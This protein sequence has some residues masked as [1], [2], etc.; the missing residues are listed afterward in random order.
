MQLASPCSDGEG[1]GG[2]VRRR[3]S[4]DRPGAARVR[5]RR[6]QEI[7]PF[8]VGIRVDLHRRVRQGVAR[9]NE[10]RA[11]HD[12]CDDGR[13]DTAVRAIH[14]RDG[15]SWMSADAPR[16]DRVPESAGAVERD[17]CVS[18]VENDVVLQAV[19][20]VV[21]TEDDA[22]CVPRDVV[23]VDSDARAVE[24]R[25]PVAAIAS[26]GRAVRRIADA[27]TGDGRA[28]DPVHV[29][30][31]H[32]VARERVV[33]DVHRCVLGELAEIDVY[34]AA[35]VGTRRDTIGR[36]PARV[37]A[38]DVPARGMLD[39]DAVDVR[40][41]DVP[42]DRVGEHRLAARG[43]QRD[44]RLAV[45]ERDEAVGCQTD[46]VA[47]DNIPAG[48][49]AR[50]VDTVAC[51]ARYHIAIRDQRPT[52]R[53]VR[54]AVIDEHA[55]ARVRESARSVGRWPDEV[56]GDD[57]PLR[58]RPRNDDAMIERHG[59]I[60]AV[61]ARDRVVAHDVVGRVDRETGKVVSHVSAAIRA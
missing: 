40:G 33:P 30:A 29:H 41:D 15:L 7:E 18:V 28:G 48:A 1:D 53:V 12:A 35:G 22:V 20:D 47:F 2:H 57:I 52:D 17:P 6:A 58:A 45:A 23:A 31:V 16:L 10:C 51:V 42:A 13:C 44:T 60:R 8:I 49:A 39:R 38:N 25:D 50:D 32:R 3:P 43:A 9:H 4:T 19:R 11:E 14:E 46:V 36:E 34:P 26:Y 5:D 61:V 55:V 59:W 54:G 27:V 24:H 21:E 37:R 56:P